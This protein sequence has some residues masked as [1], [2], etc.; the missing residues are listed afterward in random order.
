MPEFR[1]DPLVER[2]VIIASERAK[3]PQEISAPPAQTPSPLCPFCAGNESMTPPPSL[4][5]ATSGIE[6]SGVDW[7]VRVVPNKYPA[8]IDDGE[9]SAMRSEALYVSMRGA[10]VHEVVIESPNHVIDMAALGTEDIELVLQA[11]CR[12][13]LHWRGAGRWQYALIYKN[14]GVA[15]GATLAHSHSQITA[16]PMVPREA[17]EEIEAAKKYFAAAKRCA[18]CDMASSEVASGAR[19]VAD[20]DRFVVFCPFAPRAAGE[21]WL[22]PKRHSSVFEF[23]SGDELVALA[24]TLRQTL[25]RLNRC[26]NEP[27][28]NFFLHS[29]P[30]T[31]DEN[32]HYHWHMEILPRLNQYAGFELGS[33]L[34]MNP[35]AP[36]QAAQSLRAVVL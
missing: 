28:L 6:T 31:E 15:A 30:L 23:A 19:L 25:I 12:R 36:E 4:V 5:L 16:L 33:G 8:L 2:W 22:L 34:Y 21:T 27:P 11:Y 10:G 14:Q 26:F 3:R 24:H 13:L 29:N 20:T 1:K 18:F 35:L 9:F 32:A 17:F 7:R